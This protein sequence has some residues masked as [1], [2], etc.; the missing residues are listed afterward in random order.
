MVEETTSERAAE[1][2]AF[3]HRTARMIFELAETDSILAEW[4]RFSHEMRD[5]GSS[6]EEL[7]SVFIEILFEARCMANAN[8]AEAAGL[9]ARALQRRELEVAGKS[10]EAEDRL[11]NFEIQELM[12]RYNQSETLASSV[13]KKESDMFMPAVPE[14]VVYV[15]TRGEQTAANELA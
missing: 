2:T 3:I 9:L 15:P 5:E 11:G 13:R 1:Q 4:K 6:D 14:R 12:S 10:L 8:V 7:V